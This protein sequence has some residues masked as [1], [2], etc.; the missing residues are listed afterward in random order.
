MARRRLP[1]RVQ[2]DQIWV[3]FVNV[4]IAIGTGSQVTTSIVDGADWA[5]ASTGLERATMM[6]IRGYITAAPNPLSSSGNT[7]FQAALAIVHEDAVSG[8]ASLG[9]NQAYIEDILWTAGVSRHSTGDLT[10]V[11]HMVRSNIIPVN[12]QTRRRITD[13]QAIALAINVPSAG[14]SWTYTVV[15]RTLIRRK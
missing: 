10:A 8:F 14:N 13:Q 3:P 6:S 12:V 7:V 1:A 5:D 4:N 11:T 2:H 9:S 15:L